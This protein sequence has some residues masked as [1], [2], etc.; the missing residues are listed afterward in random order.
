MMGLLRILLGEI[1]RESLARQREQTARRAAASLYQETVRFGDAGS[2]FRKLGVM[3]PTSSNEPHIRGYGILLVIGG[4]P[5]AGKKKGSTGN[6]VMDAN[7]RATHTRE[8]LLQLVQA[9]SFEEVSWWLIRSTS[10]RSCGCRGS[11]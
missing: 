8:R 9:L 7:L 11:F 10:N 6:A 2:G 3:E 4:Q 1:P 5:G